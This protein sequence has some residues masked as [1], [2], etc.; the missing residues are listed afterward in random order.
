L[1]SHDAEETAERHDHIRNLSSGLVDH[2][3]INF[4]EALTGGVVH[5]SP[6]HSTGCNKVSYLMRLPSRFSRSSDI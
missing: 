2:Q 1:V 4:A 3:I 6:L 5:R